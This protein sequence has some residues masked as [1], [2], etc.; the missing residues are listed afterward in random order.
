[1]NELLLLQLLDL[2]LFDL[3]IFKAASDSDDDGSAF[4]LLGPAGAVA[5]YS[6]IFL[7]Y[8]NTDKRHQYEHKTSTEMGEV[9]TYDAKIN[10]IKG[11]SNSRM[12]GENSSSPRTRLG[13]RSIF[14]ETWRQTSNE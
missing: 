11:T 1:M 9:L 7:R 4:W 14:T 12:A 13:D 3:N 6:Y 8:R 5:F 2:N 10:E